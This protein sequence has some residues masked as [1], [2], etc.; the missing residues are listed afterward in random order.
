[1][2]R[3]VLVPLLIVVAVLAISGGFAYYFYQNYLFY[4][5]DDAQVS[6]NI[7]AVSAPAS[8]R[9][10]TLSVKQGDRV[11]SGQTLATLTATSTTGA[12]SNVDITSPITG[13]I[14]QVPTVQGQ[15]VSPG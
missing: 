4:R 2:R 5:T 9:L 15:N 7:V 10:N 11:S 6:G 12:K 8:G 1:M 13:T 14:L 3:I